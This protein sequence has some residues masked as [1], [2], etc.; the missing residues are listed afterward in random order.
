M[1]LYTW[2]DLDY[3]SIAEA[4]QVPVGTVRS[5]LNRARR[6]IRR[7]AALITVEG[8][9]SHGRTHTAPQHS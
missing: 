4:M 7:A 6:H 3:A 9:G 1:L 5:R 8:E 2:A